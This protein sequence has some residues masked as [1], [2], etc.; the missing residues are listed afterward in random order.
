MEVFR[1]GPQQPDSRALSNEAVIAAPETR[2]TQ[3]SSQGGGHHLYVNA[4]PAWVELA[5]KQD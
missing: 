1:E 3:P 4:S 5:G 2:P